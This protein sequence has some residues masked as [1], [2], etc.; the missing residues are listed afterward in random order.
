MIHVFGKI[1]KIL[2]NFNLLVRGLYDC[3]NPILSNPI[4][5]PFPVLDGRGKI[6]IGAPRTREAS[7]Y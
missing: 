5:P 1:E 6:E 7:G 2:R 4:R 3:K